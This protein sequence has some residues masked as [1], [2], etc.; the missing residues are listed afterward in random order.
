MDIGNRLKEHRASLA[1]VGLGYVGLPLAVAF[2]RH[3]SVIGFDAN[4]EK[5]AAYRE[6]H[7][8][9]EEVGDEAL[10][11]AEIEYS[12]DAAVLCR[13]LFIIVAVPTPVHADKTPDL[14]LVRAASHSLGRYLQKGS[15]VVY[16]STVYPG[17]KHHRVWPR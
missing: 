10:Q 15:I 5:I 17:D 3:F 8:V 12:A 7:D 9:T 11:K 2:A 4:E 1:V 13:A 6:G 14:G 16:E